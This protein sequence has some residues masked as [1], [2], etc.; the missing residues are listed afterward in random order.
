MTAPVPAPRILLPLLL[1]LL[2]TP[3]PGGLQ[4]VPL[5]WSPVAQAG[6]KL[7]EGTDISWTPAAGPARG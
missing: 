5:P 6:L 2:L 3:P 4:M 7:L 1:L